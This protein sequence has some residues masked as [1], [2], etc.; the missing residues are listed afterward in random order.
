M[1]QIRLFLRLMAIQRSLVRHGLDEVVT[2][3]HLFRPLRWSRPNDDGT[4]E[5][6]KSEPKASSLSKLSVAFWRLMPLGDQY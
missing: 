5:V 4:L 3:T 6:S 2:T 1:R